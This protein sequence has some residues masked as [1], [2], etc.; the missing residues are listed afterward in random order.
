[1]GIGLVVGKVV[2]NGVVRCG[3]LGWGRSVS[4]V[5]CRAVR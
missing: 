5:D 1:M 4:G 3:W 2:V